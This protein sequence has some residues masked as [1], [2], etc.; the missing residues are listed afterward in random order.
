MVIL[1]INCIAR[2]SRL[3]VWPVSSAQTFFCGGKLIAGPAWTSLI[4]TTLLV[5]GPSVVFCVLVV[6]QVA[7]EYNW[8]LLAVAIWLAGFSIAMLLVTGCSDPG[9]IPP[10][11]PP[12]PEE[13]PN[14]RP[15]RAPTALCAAPCRPPAP[16]LTAPRSACPGALAFRPRAARS[17]P[18]SERVPPRS[19]PLSRNSLHA[20]PSRHT[21]PHAALSG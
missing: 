6:P 1:S 14:G 5:L 17:R 20:S 11:P 10:L 12:G 18:D 7:R 16:R 8:V 15:R 3:R 21:L 9:I 4:G 19:S 2:R 13:F